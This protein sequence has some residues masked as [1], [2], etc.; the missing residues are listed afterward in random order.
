MHK[1]KTIFTREPKALVAI[2]S[3]KITPAEPVGI[4]TL[5]STVV[6]PSVTR[7]LNFTKLMIAAASTR[8]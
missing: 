1:S 6:P 4:P 2:F 7:G 3:R 8:S 5:P